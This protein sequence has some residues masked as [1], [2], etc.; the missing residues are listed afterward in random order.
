MCRD[1]AQGGMVWHGAGWCGVTWRRGAGAVQPFVRHFLDRKAADL[2]TN[3]SDELLD[4]I[5]VARRTDSDST[6][7][8]SDPS[9]KAGEGRLVG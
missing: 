6:R 7:V 1:V 4:A 2:R 3:Q 8:A 5:A 9:A